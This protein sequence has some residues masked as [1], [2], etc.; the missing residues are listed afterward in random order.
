M[1]PTPVRSS[2]EDR[3]Q[4]HQLELTDQ[5]G[6]RPGDRNTGVDHA[7][8]DGGGALDGLDDVLIGPCHDADPLIDLELVSALHI[9]TEL[10]QQL[11]DRAAVVAADRDPYPYWIMEVRQFQTNRHR[12]WRKPRKYGDVDTK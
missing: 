11:T 5:W 3:D 7:R 12:L 10:G 4:L 2:A 1:H 8:E 6:T 9:G